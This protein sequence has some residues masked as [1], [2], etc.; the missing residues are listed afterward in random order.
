MSC[1]VGI[2]EAIRKSVKSK[3]LVQS[4]KYKANIVTGSFTSLKRKA[5]EQVVIR[6]NASD[7]SIFKEAGKQRMPVTS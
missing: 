6:K 3:V 4:G 1:T 7:R 5:G 2:V